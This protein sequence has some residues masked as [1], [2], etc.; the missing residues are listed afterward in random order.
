MKIGLK[1][2]KKYRFLAVTLF[3]LFITESIFAMDHIVTM[4][5]ISYDPKN[6]EIKVGDSIQWKNISYTEHSATSY[7][8]EKS[9]AK[10]DTGLIQPKGISKKIEFKLPGTFSYHCQ[11]HGKTMTGNI[12][13]NP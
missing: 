10:F 5:S 7:K 11:V 6:I 1:A 13:V 9:S 8:D 4:K 2:L 12:K 3:F